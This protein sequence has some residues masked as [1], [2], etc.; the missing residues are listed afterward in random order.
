MWEWHLQALTSTH[1]GFS[2]LVAAPHTFFPRFFVSQ[3][4]C[5][6]ATCTSTAKSYLKQCPL[7]L[8]VQSARLDGQHWVTPKLRAPVVTRVLMRGQASLQGSRWHTI[9]QKRRN[10]GHH[11]WWKCTGVYLSMK[12]SQHVMTYM[13][14]ST[15]KCTTWI[16]SR[17]LE[18]GMFWGLLW[19][20]SFFLWVWFM[21][22]FFVIIFVCSGSTPPTPKD[23]F[24]S[25]SSFGSYLRLREKVCIWPDLVCWYP[26]KTIIHHLK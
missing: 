8:S 7:L 15:F 9:L 20:H 19:A 6:P 13:Y 16:T 17:Y 10:T 5:S 11:L 1:H 22:E 14:F 2:L 12:Q 21:F 24:F 26:K 23:H 4:M 25:K 3:E 18:V